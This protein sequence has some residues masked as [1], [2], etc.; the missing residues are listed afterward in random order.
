[1]NKI[2]QSIPNF[3][4]G[5]DLEKVERIVDSV[6]N[7]KNVKL[8]DYSSD[9]DH[10]RSV[11]TLLGDP[12]Q[13]VLALTR[14]AEKVAE[15][16][17]MTKHEGAHPRMGALD[18]VPI[19]PVKGVTMDDC[20]EYANQVGENIGKLGIPVYM[21]EYAAK[22]PSRKNLAKVRKGQ[23]E[24][25]F[26][27]I[28]KD[29]WKPDYGPSKM[30]AKS[31]ATAVSAREHLIAFNV[32]LNTDKIEIADAIAKKVRHIGGGLRF[33]KAMG[34]FLEDRNQA[35]VSMNLVNYKKS[36]I[37][38]VVE[39]I[40]MEAQRYGV[41]VGGTE[42][43]GLLP[44]DALIQSAEYYL[45]IENFNMEQVLETRLLEGDEDEAN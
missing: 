5:R 10:N 42:V 33:V 39:M 22:D 44:M 16:I 24:G 27:K 11:I 3:S 37:Y 6:R 31:G 40:R 1:M 30:N 18:V 34:V 13:I 35:Q 19:V 4:E 45:Q 28:E 36:S 14:L 17:D 43:I 23:Y 41:S 8:V 20:V 12:D 2:V 25:F 9:H 32:N 38:Q 21:Y 15:E 29:E 26:E 7:I